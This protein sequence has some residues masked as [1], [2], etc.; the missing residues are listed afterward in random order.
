MIKKEFHRFS[1]LG[2]YFTLGL[3]I[4]SV[5]FSSC[6][7]KEEEQTQQ[8]TT[9]TPPPAPENPIPGF[10]DGKGTM[11]A[12]QSRN[13][14][15]VPFVGVQAVDIGLAVAV[16][17]NSPQDATFLEAGKVQCEGDELKKQSNN[18]YA[19]TPGL[20]NSSGIDFSNGTVLWDVEGAGSVPAIS[21]TNYNFFPNVGQMQSSS[22]VNRSKDYTLEVESMSNADSVIFMIGGILH[23]VA[24]GNTSYTFTAAEL[25]T[26]NKGINFAQVTGYNYTSYPEGS[27]VY[28][29]VNETVL[30]NQVTLE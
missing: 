18:S 15:K 2:V 10:S 14:Q 11:V 13:F 20:T 4:A 7:K 5:S 16:F 12:V 17:Y 24:G 28:Y 9:T 3:F 27:D 6:K 21:R 26:L 30:T 22:T 1:R 19:Y 29:Y 23:I 25:G 8:P